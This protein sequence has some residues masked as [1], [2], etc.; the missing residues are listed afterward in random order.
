MTTLINSESL[1][2]KNKSFIQ[3]LQDI[4]NQFSELEK[5]N[6]MKAQLIA[7][8]MEETPLD[9]FNELRDRQPIFAAP[10]FIIVTR[11]A[12]VMEVFN[13]DEI[14]TID[15]FKD[16]VLRDIGPFLLSMNNSPEYERQKSILRLAF[17][18]ED[19]NNFHKIVVEESH[20][21]LEKIAASE[22]FDLVS[23]YARLL[24]A[25][26]IR[27]YL[28]LEEISPEKI[29]QWTRPLFR[30]VF[31][32]IPNDPQVKQEA[33]AAHDEAAPL[34]DNL[35][36]RRHEYLKKNPQQPA[37]TVLD[38]LLTMQAIPATY[39]SDREIS[40]CLLGFFMGTIDLT[41]IAIIKA[42]VDLLKRPT[43]LAA[44]IEAAKQ[45]SD[46]AIAAYVWEA[47][48]FN[49][50]GTGLFRLCKQDYTLAGGTERETHIK[51]GTLIYSA[52]LAAMH[53]PAHID[54]PTEF[55]VGRPQQSYLFFESGI[56]TCFGKYFSLVQIPLAVKVLLPLG[57]LEIA[58]KM[59]KD[60]GFPE[61]L[62]I[63]VVK[64]VK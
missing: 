44:A 38:R 49:P 12:D 35:I 5:S 25:L 21:L 19:A 7:K 16:K 64:S 32:N 43:I 53:D 10:S 58:G 55:R 34:I 8:W 39:M 18:R 30:D 42:V 20:K 28:G 63:K 3:Q 61:S 15:I 51:A 45:Q 4:S 1:S 52:S 33:A 17:P 57:K 6:Q 22:T 54:R 36:A 27:R 60:R 11:Y 29:V 41:A 23:Q 46:E 2:Q 13:N 31:A 47:L 48:R 14:F 56:H 50:P 26:A 9:F 40:N 59:T 62:P 37:I 24:P